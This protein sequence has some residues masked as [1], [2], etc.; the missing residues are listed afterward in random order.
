M[1]QSN[2]CTHGNLTYSYETVI[3]ETVPGG[4]TIGNVTMYTHTTSV[5][6]VRA[7]VRDCD[8]LLDSVPR[9]CES[10][11]DVAIQRDMIEAMPAPRMV[12]RNCGIPAAI[13]SNEVQL[14]IVNDG[15]SVYNPEND[16]ALDAVRLSLG[17]D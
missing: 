17:T 2:F 14:T 8:V 6:Q 3:K 12:K 13:L 5:H 4:L 15:R 11:L 10:L 9:G 7:N 16:L 1:S